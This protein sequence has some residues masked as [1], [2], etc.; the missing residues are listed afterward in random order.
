M[1]MHLMLN[2]I[3][4]STLPVLQDTAVRGETSWIISHTIL[5]IHQAF[6]PATVQNT[7]VVSRAVS[8]R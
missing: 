7:P 8:P 1:L 4:D 3:Y 5:Y 6:V 2:E